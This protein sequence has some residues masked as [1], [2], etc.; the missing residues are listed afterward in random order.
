MSHIQQMRDDATEFVSPWCTDP[1]DLLRLNLVALTRCFRIHPRNNNFRKLTTT[2]L[3]AAWFLMA[4][5]LVPQPSSNVF[6]ALTGAVF[7]ILGQQWEL[8]KLRLSGLNINVSRSD[9][10]NDD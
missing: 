2:V 6:L 4:T 10:S 9:E 3:F 8:E 5:N 7:L 1:V